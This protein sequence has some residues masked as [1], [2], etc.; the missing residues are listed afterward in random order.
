MLFDRVEVLAAEV[1]RQGELQSARAVV[2]R[3]DVDGHFDLPASP[4]AR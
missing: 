1:L 2:D 3:P 4:A